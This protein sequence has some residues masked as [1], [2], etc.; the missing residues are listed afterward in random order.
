MDRGAG[1][2][3]KCFYCFETISLSGPACLHSCPRCHEI[4]PGF[5][6][7][8]FDNNQARR[9]EN[10]HTSSGGSAG[11]VTDNCVTPLCQTVHTAAK[12]SHQE[13]L[14]SLDLQKSDE[15]IKGRTESKPNGD[16]QDMELDQEAEEEL[17]QDLVKDLEQE[18]GRDADLK[19]D[20]KQDEDLAQ[21]PEQ[22]IIESENT[23]IADENETKQTVKDAAALLLGDET[24]EHKL[25]RDEMVVCPSC[26][27]NSIHTATICSNPNCGAP[28][29]RTQ[30]PDGPPCF[31]C[32]KPLQKQNS[33]RCDNCGR[34]QRQV[35][36]KQIN[37]AESSPT[38]VHQDG[39][40]LQNIS[41]NTLIPSQLS[42]SQIM[43]IITQLFTHIQQKEANSEQQDVPLQCSEFND[44]TN[45]G[46]LMQ[47]W[48]KLSSSSG[49]NYV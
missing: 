29:R 24:Q 13:N 14:Q 5:Q 2:L 35:D 25:E 32:E 3:W 38:H 15:N 10:S 7:I 48:K 37:E 22:E 46:Q 36:K 6:V 4:Q 11:R 1:R 21:D 19:E 47:G 12:I 43:E 44:A 18:P 42:Q 8:K 23:D 17:E 49:K 34:M 9:N 45:F 26:G 20:P 27:H 40:S 39:L 28:L 41:Q 31:N 33:K 30:H 16:K